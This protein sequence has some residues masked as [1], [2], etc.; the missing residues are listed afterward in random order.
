MA[1]LD[2]RDPEY[3]KLLDDKIAGIHAEFEAGE[4]SEAV[5]R[6]SLHVAGLRG[7]AIDVEVRLH[8]PFKSLH[9]VTQTVVNGF[10]S[11]LPGRG[12]F[13]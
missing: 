1:L 4:I 13:R 12:G 2:R 3:R 10:V 8:R 5:Y 9:E 11:G 6:A 7:E